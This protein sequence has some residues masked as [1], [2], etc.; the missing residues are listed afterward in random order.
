[1]SLF[2]I[3]SKNSSA[4]PSYSKSNGK[5]EVKPTIEAQEIVEDQEVSLSLSTQSQA[6]HCKLAKKRE[7]MGYLLLE[8][9]EEGL[10]KIKSL[11]SGGNNIS[12]RGIQQIIENTVFQGKKILSDKE[13]HQEFLK[14]FPDFQIEEEGEC[15][16]APNL[17]SAC[18][19][20]ADDL[21]HAYRY[22]EK[23]EHLLQEKKKLIIKQ[24]EVFELYDHIDQHLKVA[25]DNLSKNNTL[26]LKIQ[27][28]YFT[29]SL[30]K[31]I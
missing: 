1:M 21:D 2:S 17:S 3:R 13:G 14:Y 4:N 18:L 6:K 30:L 8:I 16:L 12:E 24:L 26:S 10:L 11:L 31:I 7:E 28:D 9:A 15:R 5:R 27:T 19:K 22:I 29:Q 25:A 20:I 23:I